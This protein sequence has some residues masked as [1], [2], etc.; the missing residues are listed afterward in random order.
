[1]HD[2]GRADPRGRHSGLPGDEV[3]LSQEATG[4]PGRDERLGRIGHR[5]AYD[6]DLPRLDHNEVVTTVAGLVKHF[7]GTGLVPSA[8]SGHRGDLRAGQQRRVSGDVWPN[9][10]EP[11]PSWPETWSSIRLC[12]AR[13]S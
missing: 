1:M 11:L 12:M 8:A 3:E 7:A 9:V 13:P 5:R 6:V 4:S 10:H 2:P